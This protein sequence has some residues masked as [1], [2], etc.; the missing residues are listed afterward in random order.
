MRR[1][2]R[3]KR[4]ERRVAELGSVWECALPLMYALVVVISDFNREM[5]NYR[6]LMLYSEGWHTQPGHVFNAAVTSAY[7]WRRLEL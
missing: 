4:R 7:G 2:R 3:L 1:D 6:V 5:G